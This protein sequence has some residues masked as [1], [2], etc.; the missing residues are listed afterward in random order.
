MSELIYFLVSKNRV[1]QCSETHSEAA[2][3]PLSD[4]RSNNKSLN[5][6]GIVD[7]EPGHQGLTPSDARDWHVSIDR[8]TLAAI[9]NHCMSLMT[10]ALA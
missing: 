9:A 6:T 4:T 3:T 5:A 7:L 2:R 1:E 10:S 8:V